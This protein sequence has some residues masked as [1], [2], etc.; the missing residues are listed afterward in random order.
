MISYHFVTGYRIFWQFVCIIRN[1]YIIL[2]NKLTILLTINFKLMKKFTI[3]M[4]M[5][6][7]AIPAMQAKVLTKSD[8]IVGKGDVRTTTR[9][10][11]TPSI[12]PL[13]VTKVTKMRADVPDGYAQ[14]TLTA[15]DVWGDGS[16]YQMLLDADANAYGT[17]IPATGP[18]TSSGNADAAT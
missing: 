12:K 3:L 10:A 18:L 17:I 8:V 15:D 5:A 9:V 7:M 4:L 13:K 11:T 2:R 16:G 14:V 1:L 6:A